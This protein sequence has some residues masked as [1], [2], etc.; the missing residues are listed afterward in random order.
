MLI[1]RAPA[2][3]LVLSGTLQ[4]SPRFARAPFH[5]K[6]LPQIEIPPSPHFTTGHAT[7]AAD[8]PA[9]AATSITAAVAGEVR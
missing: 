3:T 9:A 7:F 5:F 6:L 1:P 2:Q 8:A 4:P